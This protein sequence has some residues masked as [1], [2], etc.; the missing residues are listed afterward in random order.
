MFAL[1]L[2][3]AA[4][5]SA[6]AA[7][8][9]LVDVLKVKPNQEVATRSETLEANETFTLQV[10]GEMHFPNN[11]CDGHTCTQPYGTRDPLYCYGSAV[12]AD[13]YNLPCA[14]PGQEPDAN[15]GVI[16]AAGPEGQTRPVPP[17]GLD[18]FS[19]G[20]LGSIPFEE[21]HRYSASFKTRR[22][23]SRQRLLAYA[24]CQGCTGEYT[25][26]IL[27]EAEGQIVRFSFDQSNVVGVVKSTTS[28]EGKIQLY[29]PVRESATHGTIG[30]AKGPIVIRH[31]D[32]VIVGDDAH[33]ELA[34][35]EGKIAYG[36]YRTPRAV[37]ERVGMPFV[38]TKSDDPDCPVGSTGR[39]VVTE[40]KGGA[41]KVVIKPAPSCEGHAHVFTERR[42]GD[43][44]RV[45]V[46]GPAGLVG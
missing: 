25:V 45:S 11:A 13:A 16:F 34:P 6:A 22:T 5:I 36:F 29:R 14:K 46:R 4:A 30:A 44:V 12:G 42:S 23:A 41:G 17:A 38:V 9:V 24:L 8:L 26:R 15:P 10:Y 39:L 27:T 18:L 43:K 37:Y 7:P 40:A 2:S 35:F 3:A 19:G 28:G 1:A 32:E 20:T 31:A 21:S 33:L